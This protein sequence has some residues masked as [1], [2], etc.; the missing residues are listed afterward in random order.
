M[1]RLD[2]LH[3]VPPPAGRRRVGV[4]G[5]LE[6]IER[7]ADGT[8]ADGVDEHLPASR[9]EQGHDAVQLGLREVDLSGPRAVRVG[10]EHRRGVRLDDAVEHQLH[11]AGLEHRVVGKRG[12]RGLEEGQV[13]VGE[14]GRC[15][16]RVVDAQVELAQPAQLVVEREVLDA[17]ARVLNAGDAEGVGQRDGAPQP[18]QPV[19]ARHG[20]QHVGHQPHGRFLEGPGGLA[21]PPVPHDGA[22][23]RV[24]RAGGDP[25]GGQRPGIGPSR[26]PVVR[27]EEGRAVADQL[28][29]LLACRQPAGKRLVVPAAPAHPRPVAMGVG[30]LGNG[31]L[32][33]VERRGAEQIQVRQRQPARQQV[34]VAVV[35]PRQDRRAMRVDH[36]RLRP[37]QALDVAIAAHAQDG[38]A[39]HGDG[40][41]KR[42][43]LRGVDPAV[44]DDEIDRAVQLV[45][46][47]PDDEPGHQ[48]AGHDEDDDVGG[49]P[50]RHA[51]SA[52]WRPGPGIAGR[53][54]I[55]TPAMAPSTGNG[56]C[57]VRGIF[58]APRCRLLPLA[59]LRR[60]MHLAA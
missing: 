30:V 58:R 16:Y 50:R 34:R 2:V 36:R 13:A 35:E 27:G 49:D 53:A 57:R 17:A 19:L 54:R 7:R 23:G 37:A 32:D 47:G 38:V 28:V 60:Q 20:R 51:A 21:R 29:E 45:T 59:R 24:W 22:V 9:V 25:G 55:L 39:P 42:G 43:A 14:P 10:V 15:R 11:R 48:R 4:G 3:A 31:P 8:I 40:L 1:N 6:G 56:P 41:G 18:R 26:V 33:L 44:G 52:A 46:L 12:A 5:P